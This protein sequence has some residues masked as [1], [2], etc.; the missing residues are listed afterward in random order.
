MNKF[1]KTA[2]AALFAVTMQ[3]QA[4]NKLSGELTV[5]MPSPAKLADKLANEFQ[6][7]TGVEVKVFQ[8]TT[9]EI[10]ARLEA[11]KANPVADVVILASW[12]DGLLLKELGVLESY[13]LPI[14]DKVVD[15][16]IDKDHELFGS[17][18]SA[19]GVIY[20]KTIIDNLN[21]DWDE[22]ASDKYKDQTAMTDP[23][24]SGACKDFLAGFVAQN[25]MDTLE[26]LAKNGMIIPGANKAAL[27]AV[28]TG[29]VAILVA[30]VDYNAYSSMKKGEPLGFYYPQGG[31]IINPR[32]AMIL[33]SAPD[34]ENAKAFVNF[35][36]SDKA[37][38]L[39]KGAF[40]IPGRKDIKSDKRSNLE[41]IPTI[42]ADWEKMSKIASKTAAD[43]NKL[44]K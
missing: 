5:Y 38:N 15:G 37:Q 34:K 33:K 39:V 29:E 27:E 32:P 8:G 20:N 35:L 36:F 18:A 25:G 43:V 22:L 7:D 21:A 19:V 9:G 14:K 42:K 41:D 3:C 40:L 28:T 31:T 10:L 23:E 17:S 26:K 4:Q 1:V 12:S 6:K 44:C 16:F 11:E 30:G 13:D 2:I 24:K